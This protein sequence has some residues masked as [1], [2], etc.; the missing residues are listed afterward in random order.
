[1]PG[2]INPVMAELA[3]MVSFQVVGNDT[4]VAMAM[5]AGQLE[6]NVMMPA[7]AYNVLQSTTILANMLRVFTE[8]CVR[9]DYGERGAVPALCGEHDCAGDG[10]ESADWVCEGG[11]AGEGVS[12]DGEVDC[13]AGAGEGGAGR[14]G[15]AGD[16]GSGAR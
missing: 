4:A 10:A 16:S 8:K 9:G 3:A 11:G 5:Q 14:R 6:L 13:G 7:M 15:D 12:G 1:M 2:K